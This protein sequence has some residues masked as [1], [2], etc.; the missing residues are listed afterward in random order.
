MNGTNRQVLYYQCDGQFYFKCK[1]NYILLYVYK[2]RKL[3]TFGNV[4]SFSFFFLKKKVIG[5][6]AFL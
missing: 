2:Y 5:E 6:N 1:M 4:N 3:R